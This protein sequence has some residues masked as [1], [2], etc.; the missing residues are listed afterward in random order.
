MF[1]LLQALAGILIIF[2]LP[3]FTLVNLM[4][5]RRGELDPE[6]DFVYR[7]TLGMGLSVV[8]A[9]LVGFLLNAASTAEHPY[10]TAGPLWAV[11]LSLT[12]VF[13]LVGW[14]RGA[15]PRAG[16][17]HPALYRA[18]SVP[19]GPKRAR[20]EYGKKVRMEKLILEREALLKDMKAFAERSSISNPQRKLYYRKRVDQARERIE[21]ISEELRKLGEEA[22]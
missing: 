6:Y 9:I 22:R 7:T 12:G 2:F 5:P 14:L 11:L 3:G 1:N 4:F 20:S 16:M 19:G 18:P 8:M 21:Q 10:V 13:A 17:I 15:Y